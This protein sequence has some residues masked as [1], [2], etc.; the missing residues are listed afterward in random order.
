MNNGKKNDAV[1][2]VNSQLKMKIVMVEDSCEGKTAFWYMFGKPCEIYYPT[3][4][5]KHVTSALVDAKVYSVQLKD[6]YGQEDYD[7]FRHLK[8]TRTWMHLL[9]CFQ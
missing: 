7:R 8:Y 1:N 6:T 4:P 9:L 5:D 2:E 3:I